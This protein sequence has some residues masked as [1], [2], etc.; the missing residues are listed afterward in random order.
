MAAAVVLVRLVLGGALMARQQPVQV[1][2]LLFRVQLLAIRQVDVEVLVALL[3]RQVITRSLAEPVAEGPVLAVP[4]KLE[5]LQYLA[6]VVVEAAAQ[7][8]PLAELVVL[9]V[10]IPPVAEGPRQAV[11]A[12]QALLVAMAVAMEAVEEQAHLV[13]EVTVVQ[14]ESLVGEVVA[15]AWEHLIMVEQAAQEP[16]EFTHGR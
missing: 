2:L 5:V 11:M 6:A 4:V 3:T 1:V 16:S 7:M 13:Q 10:H 9:G 8:E 14:A 15:Q 12:P